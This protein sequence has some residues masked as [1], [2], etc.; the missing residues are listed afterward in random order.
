M[1]DSHASKQGFGE[2][3]VQSTI[4]TLLQDSLK[5]LKSWKVNMMNDLALELSR[6]KRAAWGAFEHIEGAVKKMKNI[7]LRAHLFDTAVL[8]ALAHASET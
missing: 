2:G 3:S 6:K 4:S 8:S 5:Y 7:R 1:K